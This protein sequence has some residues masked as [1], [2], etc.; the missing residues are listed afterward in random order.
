MMRKAILKRVL[1][2][3]LVVVFLMSVAASRSRKRLAITRLSPRCRVDYRARRLLDSDNL[4]QRNFLSSRVGKLRELGGQRRRVLGVGPDQSF[5]YMLRFA[6]DGDS[7]RHQT[8][9]S[10]PTSALQ[11]FIRSLAE[12]R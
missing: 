9:Q 2:T 12:S 6:E 8:R 1:V 11:V 10:A 3:N 5:S 7:H 4:F